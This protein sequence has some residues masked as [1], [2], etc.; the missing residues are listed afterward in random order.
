ML[1]FKIT[2]QLRELKSKVFIKEI[3]TSAFNSV[4]YMLESKTH[5]VVGEPK[6]GICLLRIEDL[7]E[8]CILYKIEDSK[9]FP[10]GWGGVTAQITESKNQELLFIVMGSSQVMQFRMADMEYERSTIGKMEGH[11]KHIQMADN[12]ETFSFSTV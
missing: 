2:I 9:D 3:E 8:E 10:W 5:L 12:G 1:R 6:R 11:I 4:F 7:E